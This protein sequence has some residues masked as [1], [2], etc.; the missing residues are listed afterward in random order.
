MGWLEQLFERFPLGGYVRVQGCV[1]FGEFPELVV[2]PAAALE[3]MRWAR[4]QRMY[5]CVAHF[6]PV[7]EF[8]AVHQT[9]EQLG[10]AHGPPAG[11]RVERNLP[12]IGVVE[13]G[14]VP[15]KHEDAVAFAFLA[16]VLQTDAVEAGLH[17]VLL[18]WPV[19]LRRSHGGVA[20]DLPIH[21]AVRFTV[22]QVDAAVQYARPVDA[23]ERAHLD[24]HLRLE[25]WC[26]LP[27]R[28]LV[29]LA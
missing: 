9:D 27:V 17:A 6:R 18:A 29:V 2:W 3:A 25:T 8:D 20:G 5:P 28:A 12:R 11:L 19:G 13:A 23:G 7:G 14:F 22:V 26:C 16:R 4:G 15:G 1:Q 24:A 10:A 21:R